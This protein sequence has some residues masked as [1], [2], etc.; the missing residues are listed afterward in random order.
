MTMAPVEALEQG[1]F[2]QGQLVLTVRVASRHPFEELTLAL[3]QIEEADLVELA[4]PRTRV[5][6]SYVGTGTLYETALAVF[7]R[8]PGPF[9]I[10]P[11]RVSGMVEPE[12]GREVRF[13]AASPPI[14]IDVAGIPSEYGDDWW[15]V[16]TRLQIHESWSAPPESARDGDILRREVTV[17]AFGLTAERIRIPDHRS[18]R[19][20]RTVDAGT[21][22]RT[23]TTPDGVIGHVTRAWDLEI[24]S[25]GIVYVSPV[26]V[27]WLNPV[28]RTIE[29]A[30][31]PG[32]R[33]EPL[34]ADSAAIAERL[35]AQAEES[36][37]GK[38]WM[39]MTLAALCAAPFLALGI[40]GAIAA[41]PTRAD[42]ALAR[43]VAQADTPEALYRA[44]K[45]WRAATSTGAG[46]DSPVLAELDAALFAMSSQTPNRS[47]LVRE[48]ACAARRTRL[49]RLTKQLG[50]LWARIAGPIRQ[51]GRSETQ[52]RH[53]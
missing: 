48:L 42:R 51:L 10:P 23:E 20:V 24:G 1:W 53:G 40:A 7:P 52:T 39:A 8:Q 47:V 11:I 37:R 30:A 19:H 31:V 2:V 33:L 41:L 38:V 3:P 49:H 35:M 18:T 34:P 13:D 45:R 46:H 15:M 27:S 50:A 22:M 17:S 32:L 12:P 25:D 16:S 21:T 9:R 29:R 4:R 36:Y 43:E 26:G 14:E 6:K 5:V 44:V 28:A